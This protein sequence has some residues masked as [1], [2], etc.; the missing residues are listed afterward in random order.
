MM[1]C[2]YIVIRHWSFS[3]PS[4]TAAE[5]Y[6]CYSEPW[7]M[8]QNAFVILCR[9]RQSACLLLLNALLQFY[10]AVRII[11]INHMDLE[12]VCVETAGKYGK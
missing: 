11:S 6:V 10:I 3:N 4:E 5:L 1:S 8:N 9:G 7:V 12:Y 2:I